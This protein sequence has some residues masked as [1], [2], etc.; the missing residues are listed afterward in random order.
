MSKEYIFEF[1]G[2]KEDFINILN[3]FN[4]NTSKYS[5]ETF[6]YLDAYIVE[7][8]GDEIHFGIGRGGHS[9]GYWFLPTITSFDDRIEFCGTI[10]YI[11]PGSE[12]RGAFKKAID[13]IGKFLLLILGKFQLY[14][15]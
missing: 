7:L 15:K 6:Y 2:T 1:A 3:R 14:R 13:G 8:V 10:R 9:G 4:H 5:S 11:E 12:N